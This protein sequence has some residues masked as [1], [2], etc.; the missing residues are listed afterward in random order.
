MTAVKAPIRNRIVR[1]GPASVGEIVANP[2]NWRVHPDDQRR[3][4]AG[5]LDT[6]GWVQQVIINVRT[7]QLVD[8][9]ARVQEASERG[10]REVPAL[11]V[12]LSPEEEALVLATLDPIT[13]MATVDKERLEEL[14]SGITV[15][16]AALR[17]LLAGLR[18]PRR[19]LTDPDAAPPP[20]AEPYVQA[21][22]L[23]ILGD[24]R[25]LVGDSTSRVDVDR[26]LGGAAPTLLATDPPYG[27]E[28][29][30]EWRNEVYNDLGAAE[31]SYMRDGHRNRTISGDTK[32]DW[33]DA[34]ELVPSLRVAYVWHADV[35]SPEVAAGLRRIGFDL[36]QQIVWDKGQ[37]AMS[38]TWYHWAHE[39]CWVARR[40]SGRLLPRTKRNQA[41]VWHLTALDRGEQAHPA[42]CCLHQSDVWA[43]PSPKKLM[44]GSHEDRFDHPTQKP[45]ATAQIPIANHL[46]PGAAVYEPFSGSGT[47]LMAAETLG[48]RCYAMEIEPRYAQVAIERWQAFTGRTAVR[49]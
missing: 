12:D 20:P 45:I 4:L 47:T 22:E 37:F 21:G 14:L 36:V 5:S 27:I 24:H 44:A 11:Y 30:G 32:S 42:T 10:E 6:V 16:D 1:S 40:S 49:A 17:R 23:W 46:E 8:G 19:G 43:E 13:A 26:L 18:P 7:G 2:A 41:T 25:L 31:A 33:S 48:R 9:H 39:L 35:H 34:F 3:A 15:D 38:R 29:N 28:L